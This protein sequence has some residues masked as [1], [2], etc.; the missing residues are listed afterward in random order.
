MKRFTR[1]TVLALLIAAPIPV[2]AQGDGGTD[3]PRAPEGMNGMMGGEG[4]NGMM[5]G[6]MMPMMNM[7]TRCASMMEGMDMDGMMRGGLGDH[8]GPGSTPQGMM[9]RTE[10]AAYD[11][12]TAEALARAYL[13]GQA[14][15]SAQDIEILG[16]TLDAGRYVVTYRRAGDEDAVLVDAATGAIVPEDPR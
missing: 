2:L 8:M 1:N 7:M 16:A 15:E 14:P 6:G 10:D 13:H 9:Q 5:D 12:A 3:A 11:A 4:M